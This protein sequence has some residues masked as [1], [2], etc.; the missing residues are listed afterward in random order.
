MK[1]YIS[2]QEDKLDDGYGDIIDTW[3]KESV[4]PRV[5]DTVFLEKRGWMSVVSVGFSHINAS[6]KN[7]QR[8][9][10]ISV[11]Q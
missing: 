6:L 4:V 11:K 10:I 1:Y 8:L 3:G 7:K 9:V 2:F 5:G